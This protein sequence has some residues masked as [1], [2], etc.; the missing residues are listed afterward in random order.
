[1]GIWYTT[2]EAVMA[3]PEIRATAYQA[4]LVDRAIEASSRSVEGLLHR[5]FYPWTGTRYFDY[6]DEQHAR[7]WRLWLGQYEAISVTSM[8]MNDGSSVLPA[9]FFLYPQ[10]GPPY[11][12]IEMNT[13]TSAAFSSGST[14]QNAIGVLG[15]FGYDDQR[16]SV[17]TLT[18]G[19]GASDTMIG[20]STSTGVGIGDLLVIGTERLQVTDRL[21]VDTGVTVGGSGLS[22]SNANVALTVSAAT[23]DAGETIL[24]DSELMLVLVKA[25]AALTVQRAVQ[26]TVLATHSASTHIFA[27]RTAAVLR[28]VAGTTAATANLGAAVQRQIVPSGVEQLT[29]AMAVDAVRQFA[30]GMSGTSG[31]SDQTTITAGG[32]VAGLLGAAKAQYGR[33]GRTAAV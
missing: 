24:V 18:A 10:E 13:G 16:A 5:T 19:I 23:I 31:A 1:M 11:D 33:Q 6:P 25:G 28:G 4:P 3:A 7:S 17:T 21:Q 15:V 2:R 9:S 29:R 8:T 12:R 27:G 14:W 32:G 30:S 26:G 20:L 22:A